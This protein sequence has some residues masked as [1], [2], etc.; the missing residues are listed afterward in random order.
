MPRKLSRIRSN[1]RS[2][3][4]CNRAGEIPGGRFGGVL[5]IV[6][7]QQ[8]HRQRRH[9]RARKQIGR[10]HREHH[11]FRQRDEQVARDAGQ[12]K[13]RQ[14]HDADAQR[15][16]QRRNRDLRARLPESRCPGLRT[17]QHVA[18]D[19]FDFDGGVVHQ[20]SDRQRQAA[21]RHDVDGLAQRAQHADRSENRQRNGDGDDQRAAPA[22]EEQQN[23][24]RGEAGGDD[25]FANH[26]VHGGAHEDAIDPRWARSSAPAEACAAIFGSAS[27]TSLHDIERRGLTRPS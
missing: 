1:P 14:E 5:F 7:L 21:E 19:I 3:A 17:V 10:E 15:R 8:I 6:R 4:R 9:Q 22:S 20:N 24:R 27:R 12:E 26:A 2:K 13:H 11:R 25:R 16:N 23:H 18:V